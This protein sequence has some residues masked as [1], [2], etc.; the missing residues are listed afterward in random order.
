ML[1]DLHKAV[2]INTKKG[3]GEEIFINTIL[4]AIS[5][6]FMAIPLISAG[7]AHAYVATVGE[8]YR[9]A[10]LAVIEKSTDYELNDIELVSERIKAE[11]RKRKGK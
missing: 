8:S 4:G 6:P 9:D 5:T 3:F 2:G 11:L 10:L 7:A 1:S